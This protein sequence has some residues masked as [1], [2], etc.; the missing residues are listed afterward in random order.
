MNDSAIEATGMS[1]KKNKTYHVE[2]EDQGDQKVGHCKHTDQS[3][4]GKRY[5]G[6]RQSHLGQSEIVD[7]EFSHVSLQT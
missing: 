2:D 7:E 4:E 3:T 1:C 5:G 6:S